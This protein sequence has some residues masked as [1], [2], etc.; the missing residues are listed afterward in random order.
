MTKRPRVILYSYILLFLSLLFIILKTL[1]FYLIPVTFAGLLAM[2]MLPVARKLESWRIPKILATVVCLLIILIIISGILFLLTTQIVSFSDQLPTIQQQLN[3]K[4]LELQ[5]FISSQTGVTPQKQIDFFNNEL[6]SILQSA[7]HWG[8]NILVA[9]G[10]TLAGMGLMVIHFIF[11]L[12][13]RQRFR[14]FILRIVPPDQHEVT[15]TIINEISKI[16]RQYLTGVLTVMGILSVLNSVGLLI[17]GIQN[18]IF[19]GILAAVLNI[20]P[21]I[22]VWIGTLLPVVIAI[23]TKDSLLYP[24]GVIGVFLLTQFLDNNFLTPR[25]TGSQVQINPLA[26]IA[27]IIIGNMIWGVSGMILFI[28]LLG[29]MKIVFDHVPDLEPF[30]YLIADDETKKKQGERNK[31]ILKN[32]VE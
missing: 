31:K 18:A 21:Y 20:I 3:E 19:F 7:S 27:I 2:L 9:T 24:L 5:S 28:P 13:Y 14:N 11:F 22:G 17:L 10:G 16:T 32:P 25:I 8:T 23:I 29:M 6:D 4:F 1:S 12:L 30:A 15:A 26:T